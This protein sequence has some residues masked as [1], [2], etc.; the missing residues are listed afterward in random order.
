MNICLDAKFCGETCYR[1]K[2]AHLLNTIKGVY[3]L[4]S[5]NGACAIIHFD[6]DHQPVL[7]A[8]SHLVEELQTLKRPLGV[9]GSGFQ[10]SRLL[11]LPSH[12]T[13]LHEIPSI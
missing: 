2:H 12:G 13:E 7:G 9:E 8:S 6:P 11:R 3:F 4:H 1:R 10:Q 5:T